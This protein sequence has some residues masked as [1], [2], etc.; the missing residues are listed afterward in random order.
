MIA[1]SFS[2]T[3]QRSCGCCWP[4]CDLCCTHSSKS[5]ACSH[6][7]ACSSGSGHT[8]LC[9]QGKHTNILKLCAVRQIRNRPLRKLGTS[10]S[11]VTNPCSGLRSSGSLQDI[12]RCRNLW[13]CS[14]SAQDHKCASLSRTHLCLR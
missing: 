9:L 14:T 7:H 12:G 13:C 6:I 11:C 5:P 1:H 3:Y 10:F 2:E 4:T 8:H